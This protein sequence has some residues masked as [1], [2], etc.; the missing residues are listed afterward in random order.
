MVPGAKVS[1]FQADLSK[2]ADIVKFAGDVGE[3]TADIDILI[4]NASFWLEGNI[5]EAS[6]EDILETI[7]STAT[8]SMLISKTFFAIT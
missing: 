5:S 7:N 1:T 3:L 8:G 4:N 6:D 2:P